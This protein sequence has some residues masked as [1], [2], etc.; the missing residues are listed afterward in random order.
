[1]KSLE[2]AKKDLL[3][4]TRGFHF[5]APRQQYDV[6]KFAG[7]IKYKT[8]TYCDAGLFQNIENHGRS[9]FGVVVTSEDGHI[10]C[11]QAKFISPVVITT[12]H[13]ETVALHAGAL[14]AEEIRMLS[15]D[16]RIHDGSPESLFT[17]NSSV[18]DVVNSGVVR[19]ASR[20]VWARHWS[21]LDKLMR[22]LIEVSKVRGD[23]NPADFF[24]KVLGRPQFLEKRNLILQFERPNASVQAARLEDE[25]SKV[26][27]KAG[28]YL[29]PATEGSD[30]E[31]D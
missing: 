16:L 12:H 31:D 3:G 21:L 9:L 6:S 18:V 19:P 14:K 23:A 25:G 28:E 26:R 17:D 7:G 22:G 2:H 11:V 29:V 30:S 13:S 27:P 20:L 8:K 15:E 24:T 10:I 4:P 1:M 5:A